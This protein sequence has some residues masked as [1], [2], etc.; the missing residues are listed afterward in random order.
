MNSH[1]RATLDK[2]K[3]RVIF[4]GSY[5]RAF[6]QIENAI[7]NTRALGEPTCAILCGPSGTGKSTLCRYFE[8]FH[9]SD[10]VIRREDGVYTQLPV[11][12]CEVPSPT[13]VRGLISRMLSLL[14]D[15]IPNGTVE[16]LTHRLITCLKTA[17]VKVIFLDEIQL[18]CVHTVSEKIRLDSL[19]WI[20]SVLNTS[21]IPIILSGTELCRDIRKSH[22]PF[23]MRYPYFAELSDFEY[24]CVNNA[25]YVVILKKLDLA[26]YEI[27]ELGCG[28]HLNDPTIAA[29]LYVGTCGNLKRIRLIISDALKY[30]L[31]RGDPRELK[32]EDFCRACEVIDLPKNLA[33]TNP[34][35]LSY[36]DARELIS[37]FQAI[38]DE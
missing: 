7:E 19:Q 3:R 6:S 38:S 33:A 17:G 20:V 2:F 27:A 21:G 22:E 24:G 11:F 29:A 4:F 15:D 28:L 30:C 1:V 18:L 16:R 35:E 23:A 9:S 37:D 8:K 25:D 26:M 14:I 10:P 36:T 31:Q 5:K 32:M 12:Y 34:F 13:T